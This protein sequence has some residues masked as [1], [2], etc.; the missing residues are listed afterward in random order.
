MK[1]FKHFILIKKKHLKIFIPIIVAIII[2]V[3]IVLTTSGARER[4]EKQQ[5]V[6]SVKDSG[7]ITI[8]LDGSLGTLCTYNNQ[9]G[10][11]EGLEKDVVD[12]VL[13]R[14]FGDD[15]IIIT[16]VDVNSQTKDALITTGELDMA[17]GASVYQE[18]S[19]IEY[20]KS[21]F[22]DAGG[23]LV[24]EGGISSQA[25]LEDKTVGY[26]QGTYSSRENSENETK[27]ELYLKSQGI[28]ASVKKYASYP[29]AVDALSNG[30]IAALCAGG[31]YLK[32][33]G[34]KGML[35]LPERFMPH[36]YCIETRK[37]LATFCSVVSDVIL[38]M[39]Q[40]GTL[41]ALI[42]KWGLIDYYEL[43]EES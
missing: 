16:F 24:L 2:I 30:H 13:E 12:V 39:K 34:K 42:A 11:Y 35:I 17:L 3:V 1:L 29:E 38:E 23:F 8:G 14:L 27:L 28:S 19:S 22:A 4:S 9:T 33:F 32:L 20:S 5:A 25:Q 21:F 15:E 10:D 31:E 7:M 26:V 43:V 36:E 37:S 18:S 6:D 40:D 41:E